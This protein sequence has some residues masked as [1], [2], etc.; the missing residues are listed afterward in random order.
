MTAT[1]IIARLDVKPPNVVKGIHLEGFRVV[2]LPEEKAREYADAGADE[3]AYQDVVASLYGRNSILD[4]IEQSATG[5]FV[6]LTLGGGIRSA[7]D[8][9]KALRSGADKVSINTAAHEHPQLISDLAAR[10]GRQAVVVAIE[11]KRTSAGWTVMTQAGRDVLEWAEE[12]VGLGAGELV[13]TS[14]DNE[15]TMRGFDLDL[16]LAV[17]GLVDVPLVAHGGCGSPSDVVA[18][19]EAGADAVAVASALHYGRTTISDIKSAV[20]EAGIEVRL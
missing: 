17:R 12:A 9:D 4:L 8:A 10:F 11:A 1:R 16:I 5:V 14:I 6:P 2:G 18:A 3:I 19:V 15:G 13:L 7:D 20:R